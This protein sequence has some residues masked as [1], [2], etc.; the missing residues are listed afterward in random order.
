MSSLVETNWIDFTDENMPIG[1]WAKDILINN[2]L[3][4]DYRLIKNNFELGRAHIRNFLVLK[5]AYSNVIDSVKPDR[6]VCNDSFYG[7]WAILQ[8]LSKMK[9]ISFYSSWPVTKDRIAFASDDAAMN[10]NFRK[11][12]PKFTLYELTDLQKKKIQS[13]LDGNRGLLINTRIL[14]DHQNVY[15][16]LGSINHNKPTALLASNLIWD[17]GALNKQL[18]FYDMMDWIVQTIEWFRV[19]DQY[20]LIIKPHPAETNPSIRATYETVTFGLAERSVVCPPNVFLLSSN[21]QL[22]IYDIIPIVQVGLVHTTTVG[23]EMAALGLPVITTAEA[24]YRGFG[25]TLD[26]V[27]SDEYFEFLEGALKQRDM[28][29]NNEIISLSFK[30]I[31]LYQFHY[32]SKIGLFEAEWG[33]EPVLNVKSTKQLM[34]GQ[35]RHLDYITDS[36]IFGQPIV[37]EERWPSES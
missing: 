13:W 19:H 28:L 16:E 37:S 7:L 31:Q 32:F 4:G 1:S 35:N 8:H 21:V 3:V 36:I 23:F 30:F 14:G 26:P 33:K 6:I 34:P 29:N 12:W 25:F 10:L 24:P 17:L 15:F 9:G 2:Y 11:A 27:T 18:L 5:Q 22:T 20:Q